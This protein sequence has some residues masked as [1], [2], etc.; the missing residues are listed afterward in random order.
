MSFSIPLEFPYIAFIYDFVFLFSFKRKLREVEEA[1]LKLSMNLQGI[2]CIEWYQ[3][4]KVRPYTYIVIK[5]AG[6][7]IVDI[8]R[9]MYPCLF[10]IG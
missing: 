3:V 2:L 6:L 9:L 1:K 8:A 7:A 10:R 4:C 5:M